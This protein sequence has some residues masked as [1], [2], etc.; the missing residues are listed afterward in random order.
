MGLLLWFV[1]QW[2][3]IPLDF[4]VRAVW[5]VMVALGNGDPDL[6]G[7][8]RNATARFLSPSK[9]WV[10]MSRNPARQE[11]YLDEQFARLAPEL[12]QQRFSWR[13][14]FYHRVDTLGADRDHLSGV[15]LHPREYRG[16]PSSTVIRIA[17]RH[18]LTVGLAW[19]TGL[20]D[21][22][23]LGPEERS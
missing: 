17:H 6:I 14:G 20:T 9:L 13:T 12:V 16:V 22:L 4:V 10:R 3:L 21:G 19:S 11:A 15:V 2:V 5:L 23:I 8:L 18:H 7:R 1:V